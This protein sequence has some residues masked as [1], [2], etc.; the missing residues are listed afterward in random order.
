MKL[1]K[2]IEDYLK[3]VKMLQ[4]A[5]AKDNQPWA[6]TV[7]FAFDEKLNLYWISKP[8]RRHSEEIRNNDKVA[9]VIVLSHAPG[10]KVRGIQFQGVAKELTNKNEAKPGMKYYAKRYGMKPERVN[11]ILDGTD[12]HVCYKITPT[13]YVLFDEVNFPDNPRQE[14]KI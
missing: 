7:Y 10:D 3:E 13:L 14:Y 9:G 5:T 11:A 12:G 6:C 2:L 4:V 8:S 1:R